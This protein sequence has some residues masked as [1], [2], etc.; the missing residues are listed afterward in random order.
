MRRDEFHDCFFSAMGTID[1]LFEHCVTCIF[2]VLNFLEVHCFFSQFSHHLILD[3]RIV[4]GTNEE[5]IIVGLFLGWTIPELE[6]DFSDC[7]SHFFCHIA[8]IKQPWII[9]FIGFCPLVNFGEKLIQ[10][11]FSF[12]CSCDIERVKDLSFLESILWRMS[13]EEKGII[14]CEDINNI[15]ENLIFFLNF[16]I[17]FNRVSCTDLNSVWL[18]GGV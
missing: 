7:E 9:N 5:T 1:S 12:N 13:L 16:I 15:E 3:G 14:I 8:L 6:I 10:F 4:L 18:Y 17:N 2:Y 11:F